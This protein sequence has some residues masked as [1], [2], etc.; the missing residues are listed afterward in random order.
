MLSSADSHTL[1]VTVRSTIGCARGSKEAMYH[2]KRLTLASVVILLPCSPLFRT[3]AVRYALCLTHPPPIFPE[4]NA[5]QTHCVSYLP[6]ASFPS[7]AIPDELEN[8]TPL[9]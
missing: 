3:S 7:A 5:L 2:R 6:G 8:R 1:T 4:A 9:E